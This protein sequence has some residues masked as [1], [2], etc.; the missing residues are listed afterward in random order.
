LNVFLASWQ[1]EGH[2][3]RIPPAT[4]RQGSLLPRWTGIKVPYPGELHGAVE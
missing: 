2:E 3:Q 1:P 4:E